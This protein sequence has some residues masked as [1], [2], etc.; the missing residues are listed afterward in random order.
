MANLVQQYGNGN[1]NHRA[2]HNK[3][4][5]VQQG[6]AGD[7][8]GVLGFE[9]VGKVAQAHPVTAQ[10]AL[11]PVHL[12]KGDDQAGH[13]RVIVHKQVQ[14]PWKEHKVQ[15]KVAQERVGLFRRGSPFGLLLQRFGLT[16]HSGQLLLIKMYFHR[17]WE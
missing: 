14:R 17:A 11:A 8:E 7:V 16:G 13:G 6:V 2:Q 12:F 3:Y 5:I 15:G 10:D 9:Q 1:G 4:H